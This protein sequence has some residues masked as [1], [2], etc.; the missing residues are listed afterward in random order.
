MG[1][2]K[3]KNIKLYCN[4]G[5]L[6]EEAKIGS[7]YLVNVKLKANL[8]K[9][10]KSDN[11]KDT[12]DY[13][14]IHSIVKREMNIRAKLLE[15]VAQRIVDAIMIEYPKVDAVSVSVAK[16]NPPIGGETDEVSVMLKGK[17]ENY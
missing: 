3:I 14:L 17:R 6:E 16:I 9:P 7:D 15:V 13:V 2:I 10:S 4:H 1:V 8:V 5:C 11:L 12:I